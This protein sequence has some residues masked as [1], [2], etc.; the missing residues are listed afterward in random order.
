MMYN[1]LG[2]PF[3]TSE[4]KI[5]GLERKVKALQMAYT[6]ALADSV[7]RYGKAGILDE[8]TKEKRDE[9]MKA[10]AALAGRFGVKEPK[11]AFVNVQDLFECADWAY[12]DTETG[13]TATC[14]NCMLCALCKKMGTDSPCRI[15]CLSPIEASIKGIKPDAEFAVKKTLWDD[16]RCEVKVSYR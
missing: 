11:Q 13:F 2:G 5:A 12:E 14:G 1:R 3:M 16:S 7:L 9:Q 10:G 15:Y 8:V 6:G 4:E